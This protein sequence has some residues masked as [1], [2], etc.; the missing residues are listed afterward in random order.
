MKPWHDTSGEGPALVLIH[1][2][3]LHSDV[4]DPVMEDLSRHYRVTRIDL[5]GH[6]HSREV[7]VGDTL[8]DWADA[9]LS[10][11]PET[12]TWLGWSLGGM[13]A[14]RAA[15]DAPHRVKGLLAVATTPRFVSDHDWPHAMAPE[16]LEK[17]AKELSHDFKGTVQQFLALQ[18]QGDPEARP[19]LRQLRE[20]VFRHGEP[21]RQV[22]ENG[23][24]LLG[25]VDLRA[26]LPRLSQPVRVIS[27]RLDRLTH[28][29]AGRAMAQ[30]LPNADYHCLK[31]TA[32]APFLSDPKHFLELIH[33]FTQA[34]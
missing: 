11:A 16:T 26:E 9:A 30:A 13:V 2:W 5:P 27:G 21:H 19:M 22:L 12:A 3:G 24:A 20:A 31:R 25:S 7:P 14:S 1:G 23:L 33:D 8:A 28:P 10:V 15:L 32:H 4:W 29:E 6:G 17:F 34:G 18:V